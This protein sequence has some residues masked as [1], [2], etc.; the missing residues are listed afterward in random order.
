MVLR[1]AVAM[2]SSL[3]AEILRKS[4]SAQKTPNVTEPTLKKRRL[5]MNLPAMMYH[6]VQRLYALIITLFTKRLK[7]NEVE[8][9]VYIMKARAEEMESDE[10]AV[11]AIRS[12]LDAARA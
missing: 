1:I 2:F 7:I 12:I 3:T 6:T 8:A 4:T 10:K 11:A 9:A 5:L